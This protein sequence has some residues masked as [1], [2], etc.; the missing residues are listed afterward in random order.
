MKGFLYIV[1]SV[2]G[3]KLASHIS[4]RLIGDGLAMCTQVYGPVES[5]FRWKGKTERRR[6]WIC[7]A[8]ARASR[9]PEIED[10]IRSMHPDKVPEIISFKV[11]SG[12]PKYMEWL[13]SATGA[14]GRMDDIHHR[15]NVKK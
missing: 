4:E 7:S 10:A 5:V 13:S 1:T 6:E 2:P 9:Y 3:E 11:E 12:F 14:G 15:R 8:K